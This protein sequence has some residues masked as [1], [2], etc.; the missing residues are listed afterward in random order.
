MGATSHDWACLRVASSGASTPSTTRISP[1][2]PLLPARTPPDWRAELRLP[3]RYFLA[4]ARFVPKKNLPLLLEAFASY[5]ATAGDASWDLVLVGDGP[6]RGNLE[7]RIRQQGLEGAVQLQGFLQYEKLPALY[8]LA[9]AFILPSTSE[10]WG[11]VVNEAMAAGLPVAVSSA[12]GSAEDLV[13]K[14]V[15]GWTFEPTDLP[16]LANLLAEIASCP[17]LERMGRASQTIISRLDAS[18]FGE[19]LLQA[20]QVARSVRQQRSWRPW[21]NPLLWL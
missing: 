1:L 5:R 14:G 18:A 12:C 21:P 2:A 10:Q 9:S 8:G 3:E 15:N 7:Q 6:L 17:A 11:L 4:V 19:G 13:Q 16:S 20:L